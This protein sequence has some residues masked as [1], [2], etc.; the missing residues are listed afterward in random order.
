MAI[1]VASYAESDPYGTDVLLE[2][3]A[4]DT[5]TR[6]PCDIVCVIDVSGSMNTPCNV[7]DLEED[8]DVDRHT[9]ISIVKHCVKT[10][11]HLLTSDDR[12][13]I[14]TYAT[15]ASV[16]VPLTSMA[17][18]AL[19]DILTQI[20]SINSRG[21]TDLWS[22]L[23]AGLGVL[24]HG[25]HSIGRSP[26]V[27][28]LSDGKPNI[29]PPEGE[30]KALTRYL[31]GADFSPR[32]VIHTYAFGYGAP[33]RLLGQIAG[34]TGGMFCFLPD[35]SLVGS[36]FV[37]TLSSILTTC[38]T[39]A[40]ISF[41]LP[42]GVRIV[43]S[44]ANSFLDGGATA[45]GDV[46]LPRSRAHPPHTLLPPGDV[47][48]W[49]GYTAPSAVV[50]TAA[51]VEV[52]RYGATIRVGALRLGQTRR[53]L[54]RLGGGAAGGGCISEP[55]AVHAC[56]GTRVASVT[57]T[58]T[59]MRE[60]AL[61]AE[62]AVVVDALVGDGDSPAS[63]ELSVQRARSALLSAL[64]SAFACGATPLGRA[65]VADA[66]GYLEMV[67]A[68]FG[69]PASAVPPSAD[70]AQSVDDIPL[71]DDDS[72]M[73]PHVPAAAVSLAPSARLVAP[74]TPTARTAAFADD[75]SGQ[76]TMAVS[77]PAVWAKWGA[78]Y[79]LAMECAHA[80]EVTSN[81]MDRG[82]QA[83][84]GESP[85]FR[86]LRLAGEATFLTI[87]CVPAARVEYSG[88]VAA[89]VVRP[90]TA[91]AAGQHVAPQA[92]A[93]Q[94]AHRVMPT[95]ASSRY[96]DPSGGC[97]CGGTVVRV[98][99]SHVWAR[100][101]IREVRVGDQIA[102]ADGSTAGTVAWV[103]RTRVQRVTNMSR[104]GA[105]VT[106]P[107]HP[108][109]AA[110]G[111]AWHFPCDAV[112][113]H[114]AYVDD[115][116]TLAVAKAD[117][118]PAA[119]FGCAT[120]AFAAGADASSDEGGDWVDAITIAHGVVGDATASHAFFGTSDVIKALTA[121]RDSRRDVISGGAQ[122]TRTVLSGLRWFGGGD[123][124]VDESAFVRGNDGR[125]VG[126]EA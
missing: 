56:V 79:V 49:Q 58:A 42:L 100:L 104:S 85:P 105:L 125:I 38:V 1:R 118:S 2:V 110:V 74:S 52:S 89:S 69:P 123:V 9:A 16:V 36:V 18:S 25:D 30:V 82:L 37:N 47:T 8:G 112:G 44:D 113:T 93:V 20:E 97:L 59:G 122:H 90:L 75:A 94:R 57:V 86:A 23:E 51:R 43:T 102:A 46:T 72:P 92:R 39:D 103:L 54:V 126:L 10:V 83:Y 70:A 67:S 32:P 35:A 5:R 124:T 81:F 101:P 78:L 95:S 120:T 71:P 40:V 119:A 68:S 3:S 99:R 45:A 108:I 111:R 53:F 88:A 66:A 26:H 80:A 50:A 116:V 24:R 17:P 13:S 7:K 11:A 106:T 121:L 14:V 62:S 12:L 60:C 15:D 117:G 91:R 31:T 65:V 76:V 87:P 28:L 22:G 27:I 98:A 107:W 77:E 115:L 61:R 33:A 73:L 21:E 55:A 19:G 84:G 109:R 41:D 6:C 29:G 63:L 48:T 34:V 64:R 114:A 96:M 4:E